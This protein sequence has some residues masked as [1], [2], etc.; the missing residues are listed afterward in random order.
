VVAVVDV[1][2]TVVVVWVGID[3]NDEQKG[4]AL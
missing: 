1:T 2:D 4:V 3:R